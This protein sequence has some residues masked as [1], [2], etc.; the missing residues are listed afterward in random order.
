MVRIENDLVITEYKLV[1]I[2][3]GMVERLWL[4]F[5]ASVTDSKPQP[6]IKEIENVP[7]STVCCWIFVAAPAHI[8]VIF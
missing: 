8:V 7:I 1:L 5:H 3:D 6:E 2:T 4:C